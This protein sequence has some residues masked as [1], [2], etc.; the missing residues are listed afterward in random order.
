MSHSLPEIKTVVHLYFFHVSLSLCRCSCPITIERPLSL[1]LLTASLTVSF[2]TRQN[3]CWGWFSLTARFTEHLFLGFIV[4]IFSSLFYLASRLVLLRLRKLTV[5]QTTGR[6]ALTYN[7]RTPLEFY[8]ILYLPAQYVCVI[9]TWTTCRLLLF[10]KLC[11][12]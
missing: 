5:L 7:S 3:H 11:I 2:K 10:D 12:T 9:I 4:I 6:P 8:F 1:V